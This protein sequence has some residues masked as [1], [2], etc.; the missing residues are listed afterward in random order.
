MSYAGELG[1]EIHGPREHLLSVYDA[2]WAN[3]ENHGIAD[4]G[5]F[6]MNSL[7]MEKA[8]KG[9][10]ELTNEVTLPEADV[11][12]FAKMDGHDFVGKDATERSLRNPLPWRC[13]YLHIDAIETDDQSDGHGGEAVLFDGQPVG[14]ISSIAYGHGVEKLVA[15]AYVKPAA[16]TPGTVLEVLILNERRQARVV[17]E[18]M[19][20]P[21][22]ERPRADA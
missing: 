4:Y 16:A 15:F 11:M 2:L 14:S 17:A 20:D 12:R 8:F 13:V 9:A 5:S 22:S 3:G 6:A 7:R 1:Y 19:Y 10:A 18:P 21:R